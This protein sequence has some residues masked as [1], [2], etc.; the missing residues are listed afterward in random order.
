MLSGYK[1]FMYIDGLPLI[2]KVSTSKTE[3]CF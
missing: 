2:K 1:D 3:I